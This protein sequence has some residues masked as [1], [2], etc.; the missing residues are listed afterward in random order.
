M[1]DRALLATVRTV[2]LCKGNLSVTPKSAWP[3]IVIRVV[4]VAARGTL[5]KSW[6]GSAE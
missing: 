5:A 4:A 1:E 6:L 2:S 3:S